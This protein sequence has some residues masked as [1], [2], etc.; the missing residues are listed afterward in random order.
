MNL[1]SRFSRRKEGFVT[2]IDD[3]GV[4][5][6]FSFRP[7]SP[8]PTTGCAQPGACS[9]NLLS[10][11]ATAKTGHAEIATIMAKSSA[12]TANSRLLSLA[13]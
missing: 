13:K 3:P 6:F 10:A 4:C 11:F 5:T 9:R 12:S 2:G 7:A 1:L 8:M